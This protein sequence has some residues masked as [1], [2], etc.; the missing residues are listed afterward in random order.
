VGRVASLNASVAGSVLLFEVLGQRSESTAQG[1]PP[2]PTPL[3][4]PG[5]DDAL[6]E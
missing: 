1:V 2:R 4:N 6:S 5:S 3:R